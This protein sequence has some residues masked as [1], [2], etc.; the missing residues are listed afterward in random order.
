[1]EAKSNRKK[2][3][4]ENIAIKP[5]EEA[6]ID[7]DEDDE[8]S[9]TLNMTKRQIITRAT[10]FLTVGTGVVTFFS[11]PMVGAITRFGTATGIPAFYVSFIVAP[12]A[13]NASELIAAIIFASKRKKENMTLTM[14]S[15]YGAV[16]MNNTMCLGLFLA[17][18]AFQGLAWEFSAETI[19]IFLVTFIV[20]VVQTLNI[21]FKTWHAFAILGLYPLSLLI[22]AI[23]EIPA[24]N[25]K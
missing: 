25:W 9:P 6:D 1:M 4:S 17:L 2:K 18:I 8:T 23:L 7:E 16:T 20:G 22:V 5:D 10:I 13:S 15:L 19:V 3:S 12:L 24:I 21:T 14:S 11:D